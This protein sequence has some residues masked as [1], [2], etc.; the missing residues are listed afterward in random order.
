MTTDDTSRW[1]VGQ[2]Q[3]VSYGPSRS[4][5]YGFCVLD[6]RAAP[7]LTIT[8]KTQDESKRAEDLVREAIKNAAHIS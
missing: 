7:L 4:Y 1:K 8:Y 2:T 6:A 3:S 5:G